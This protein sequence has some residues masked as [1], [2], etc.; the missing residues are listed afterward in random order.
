MLICMWT[1]AVMF[2]VNFQNVLCRLQHSSR[3]QSFPGPDGPIPPRHA[4]AAL[5]CPW[6][7]DVCTHTLVGSPTPHSWWGSEIQI[8]LFY[9]YVVYGIRTASHAQPTATP[10]TIDA[11]SSVNLA[12]HSFN[13]TQR[14]VFIRKHSVFLLLRRA[15]AVLILLL[16][17][18]SI[19]KAFLQ[20]LTKNNCITN[21][22]II[23]KEYIDYKQIFFAYN[24]IANDC[25]LRKKLWEQEGIVF[26]TQL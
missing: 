20:Y 8:W 26:K 6:S 24:F 9:G 10:T 13:S 3:Y 4:G 19:E 15:S 5:P 2:G 18:S 17:L 14:P 25:H 1:N 7:G 21:D 11:A 23:C 16:C 22:V 12:Q